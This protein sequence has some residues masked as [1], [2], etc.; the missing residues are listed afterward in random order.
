MHPHLIDWFRDVEINPD[1]NVVE[2]RWNAAAE[3]AEHLSRASVPRLLRLFL[4]SRPD[5]DEV[6]WL[7]DELLPLDPK[8]PVSNN[9]R[10]ARLMAG[11]VMITTFDGSSPKGY[12]F[13]L[14]LRIAPFLDRSLEQAQPAIVAEA[15]TYLQAEAEKQRPN[16]FG[17][18]AT[19]VIAHTEAAANKAGLPDLAY[20]QAVATAINGMAGRV[21]R[22]GEETALLWW[23]LTEYSDSLKRH[24]P[25]LKT[26]EYALVAGA[27]AADRTD[28]LPPPRSIRPLI[29]RALKPCKP[30][31][32]R[33][34]L[35]LG[36]FLG[37]ADSGWRADQLKK[38]DFTDSVDLMPIVTGLAKCQEFGSPENAVQVL[39]KLCPGLDL[40]HALSAEE[41]AYQFY[42]ELMF[43]KALGAL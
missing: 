42:G 37:A 8:F 5:S 6:K 2:Q 32:K 28:V 15:E 13:A 17:Q 16:D 22:L 12:A 21:R 24:T 10:I 34:T 7:T 23:V 11:V 26:I 3:F 9:A 27:E 38:L 20:Q 14:G 30:G 41:A 33:G 36:D 1:Q 40:E 29:A 18:G 43:L 39:P 4:F 25:D 19:A 31:R 35:T